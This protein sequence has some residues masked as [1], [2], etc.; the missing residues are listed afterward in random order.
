M[1]TQQSYFANFERTKHQK[2]DLSASHRFGAVT[3]YLAYS[4]LDA[5]LTNGLLWLKAGCF[6][7]MTHSVAHGDRSGTD[8]KRRKGLKLHL[9]VDTL[10]TLE[11]C[12]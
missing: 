6:K 1:A 12:I 7:T 3:T 10:G 4:F 2:I 9:A 8:A 5:S 11:P